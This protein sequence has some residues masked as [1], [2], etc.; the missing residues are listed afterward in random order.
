M[1][2]LN[3]FYRR[4]LNSLYLT[5]S[6]LHFGLSMIGIFVPIYIFQLTGNFYYLPAFYG[7]L[8]LTAIFSLL[9]AP[10]FL[11]RLGAGRSVLLANV[12]RILNLLLLLLAARN[13]LLILPAAI[14]EGLTIPTF[15]VTYHSVFLASGKDGEFGRKIAWM[16]VFVSVVSALAPFFGGL[17]VATFGFPVLYGLGML[18][19]LLSSIPI[20]WVGD[21][22][23]F[24]F[25]GAKQILAETFSR[26]WRPVLTGFLGIRLEN[27][28]AALFWPLFLFG[29]VKSFTNLGA[30][31]SVFAV[32][33]VALMV[34]AGR[35]VDS[36]GSRRVFKAGA[37]FL[38]PFWFLVGFFPGIL[39]LAVLN[40]YRGLVAPFYGIG[41][42]S[43]F[44]KLAEKDHFLSVIK[45][46][47]S[48]HLSI[49]VSVFICAVL[50]FFFPANWPVLLI[51]AALACFLA[52][53][54]TRAK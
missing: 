34:V 53:T 47:V 37:L 30:V 3:R 10:T 39:A 12:F 40:A 21:H 17:V 48:I 8:S 4:P 49:L 54:L 27:V 16:G 51:P 32:V 31:T 50:W 24:R 45:R 42:E 26:P 43:L 1:I 11:L 35:V 20:L 13:P 19:I 5:T 29:V 14:F 38:A 33:E 22:L 46:E 52:I 9:A 18:L 41:A 36:L 6:I 23:G 2:G 28:I 7:V 15:W 44:Y 25:V